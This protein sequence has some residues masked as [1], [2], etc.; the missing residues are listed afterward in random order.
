MFTSLGECDPQYLANDIKVNNFEELINKLLKKKIIF[1]DQEPIYF[2]SFK[3]NWDEAIAFTNILQTNHILSNSEKNSVEKTSLLEK[4]GWHDFYWFSNGF[5]SL[6]WYRYF[7][8]AQYLETL[9][10]PTKHFSS[11]NRIFLDRDHRAIISGFLLENHKDKIILSCHRNSNNDF[12]PRKTIS[13]EQK[14]YVDLALSK[15]NAFIETKNNVDDNFS[16]SLDPIDFINSFC[17]IVTERIYYEDRIHLTEKIFKPIVCCR[18]FILVSS[19]RSLEYLKNY[20]FKTFSNFWNEDYDSIENHNERMNRI[21]ILI[22]DIAKLSVSEI[23]N[24][25][26]EMQSILVYNRNHFYNSFENLITNELHLNLSSALTKS[27]NKTPLVNQIV[28]NLTIEE[29]KLLD[30]QTLDINQY[31]IKHNGEFFNEYILLDTLN[32]KF[33]IETNDHYINPL[34]KSNLDMVRFFCACYDKINT[35]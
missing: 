2:N 30:S 24:M 10:N 3:S 29:K 27:N 22:N 6:D 19:P 21:L 33:N 12:K 20:G 7:K 13:L 32:N 26:S 11:Y 34:V 1:H 14:K 28:D 35:D 4:S 17:H 8:H 16:Y 15:T 5:L 9:W 23:K 25:L 31:F 18:P